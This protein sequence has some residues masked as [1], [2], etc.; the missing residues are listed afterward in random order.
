MADVK[1][2]IESKLVLLKLRHVAKTEIHRIPGLKFLD[3]GPSMHHRGI[4]ARLHDLQVMNH[5]RHKLLPTLGGKKL[6]GGAGSGINYSQSGFILWNTLSQ[7]LLGCRHHGSRNPPGL[8]HDFY[9]K[10]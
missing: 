9:L 7:R 4:H 2:A 5:W 10:R 8:F 3:A 6:G 1:H